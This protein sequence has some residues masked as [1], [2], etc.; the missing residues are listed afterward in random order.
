MANGLTYGIQFPFTDSREGKYLELTQLT[1]S[2]IRTDLI[3]LI[4]TRKG[5]RYFLPN[6]GTRLYEFIF[7]PM[8]GPTFSDIQSEIR[9]SV[10]EYIPGITISNIEITDASLEDV[11]SGTYINENDERVYRVPGL[12]VKEYTAKVKIDYTINNSAFNSSD[13]VIINI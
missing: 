10:E 12:G 4:L 9:D 7:E 6:F 3:H 8:D 11:N 5:S 1:D 2:E 13:F